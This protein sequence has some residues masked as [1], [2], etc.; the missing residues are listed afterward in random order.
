MGS[1]DPENSNNIVSDAP[2]WDHRIVLCCLPI[3]VG[4]M[5]G[6]VD[7]LFFTFASNSSL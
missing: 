6:I 5:S 2:E 1:L 3:G 4:V 7:A